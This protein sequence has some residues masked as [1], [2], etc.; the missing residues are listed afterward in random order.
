MNIKFKKH[1]PL[2]PLKI[3]NVQVATISSLHRTNNICESW[4]NSFTHV[5]GHAHPS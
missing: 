2:F 3:W 4:N 5:V 1:E